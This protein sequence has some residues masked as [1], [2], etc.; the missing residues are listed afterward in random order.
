[1][2]TLAMALEAGI[3]DLDQVYD[4][5]EALAAGPFVIKDTY[6]QGRPLTDGEIFLHSRN[7]GAGML[8]LKAGAERQRAFLKRMGLTEPARTEARP[9]APPQLPRHW[10]RID[11]ITVGY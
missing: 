2:L 9:V 11:T 3:A 10:G 6:P 7:V 5:R 8:A 1:M 4:V